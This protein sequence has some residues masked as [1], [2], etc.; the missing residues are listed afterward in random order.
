MV[1]KVRVLLDAWNALSLDQQERHRASGAPLG[2]THE[3]EAMPLDDHT[4]PPD[5]HARLANPRANGGLTVL[6]RGY[7][8]DDGLDAQGS[9]DAGL[10]L[11]LYQRDPRRQFIPLHCRLAQRDAL[12][13]FT[14]T[15]GSYCQMLWMTWREDAQT[16]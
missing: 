16:A 7:S 6:R 15:V 5:A 8:Y 2:R 12:T 14:R 4:V 10:V 11:L 13:R 9:A 1:R 3:F